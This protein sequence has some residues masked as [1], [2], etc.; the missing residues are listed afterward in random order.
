ML[1]RASTRRLAR[2]MTSAACAS[3][4]VAQESIRFE[5]RSEQAGLRSGGRSFGASVGDFDGDGF[6]DLFVGNHYRGPSLDHGPS[7]FRNRRDG[8]FEEVASAVFEG[9]TDG[10]LHGA[11]WADFDG[12]GDQDLYVAVGAD[13]GLGAQP[14]LCFVNDA[15]RGKLVESAEALGLDAPLA[16]GRTPLWLPIAGDR[17]LAL[18]LTAVER[19]DGAA[20]TTLF[21]RRDVEGR[22]EDRSSE[23][24]LAIG[25][26]C[27]FAQLLAPGDGG[28]RVLLQRTAG[29]GPRWF[30]LSTLPA[31]EIA[32]ASRPA[33]VD[34][35][36]DSAL[37]DFDGDGRADLFLV[38]ASTR[39]EV[40][41][42]PPTRLLAG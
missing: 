39:T 40:L 13:Y 30:D 23:S 27:A 10:D 11:A 32:D 31:R 4:A 34:S 41:L 28:S 21:R 16:R 38:R 17:S 7:L 5:E 18:L 33:P 36:V 12:D 29:P 3:T 22:Y 25:D 20:A 15:K 2:L 6:P 14:K 42:E 37:G 9:R 26:G 8:T 35:V 1:L 24:G 19:P